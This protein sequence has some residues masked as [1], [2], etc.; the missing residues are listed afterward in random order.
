LIG[1]GITLAVAAAAA[2][3]IWIGTSYEEP[4]PP[5]DGGRRLS[6]LGF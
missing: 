2:G 6:V 4:A 3:A 1:T 5:L